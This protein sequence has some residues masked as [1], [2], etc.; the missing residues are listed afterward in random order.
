M[1]IFFDGVV[2]TDTGFKMSTKR[3]FLTNRDKTKSGNR[4][5]QNFKILLKPICPYLWN[6]LIKKNLFRPPHGQ[7]PEL[8][9]GLKKFLSVIIP[10]PTKTFFVSPYEKK[11]RFLRTLLA[12]QENKE[13]FTPI[14]YTPIW[15]TTRYCIRLRKFSKN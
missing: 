2:D 9:S 12:R 3:I 4:L 10:S 8:Q 1:P 11:N 15:Y 14:Q 5:E 7:G 6:R 13:K